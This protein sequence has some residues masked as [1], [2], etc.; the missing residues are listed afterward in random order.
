MQEVI[1]RMSNIRKTFPGV[2]A[3]DEVDLNVRSGTVH[4]LM[5]EN[6]AGKST[7]MKCLI[8]MYQPDSGSVELA[9]EEMNFKDTK[10]GLEHGISMIHQEL[11]PVPEMMVAEN[12]W[13]GRE[14]RGPLGLLDPR[15]MIRKT[16]ELFKEWDIDIDPRAQMK[17]LSI[18]KQQMVEIAKAIS[19]DAKI[20]I[21]D[22]PTS[23]IPEREVEHLHRMIKRLTD[24]GVA[25]IYITHKMDEVFKISD[26]ITIFRD[27]KHV[28]SYAAKDL[29]RDKLIKLMVGRE[30][31]DLFPKLEA[32]IGDVVLSVR[33]LTRGSVV[34]DVSFDLRRGE[35]LGIAGLMGAGRT[36]VL[37]TIFGIEKADSGEIILD[38]KSLRI[39]QPADAIQANLALLTEDRKLN[40]IM[41]VL[42][43]GD[44][45]TVA[46]LPRYSPGG[47]LKVS[48]MRKDS[49]EQREKLRIKTPS[50]N[51]LIKNL[52]GGN[53]QKALISRWLLTVPDVLLIDEPTR[54]IDVGAKSE[55]H[56]LMSLL[57]RQG[58][59]I[60]MVSSE[61]PEVLG[62]SD[63]I[64][65]MHEGRISGE[66]S[67]EEANQE[68]VMHLATGGDGVVASEGNPNV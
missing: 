51:Q 67:R 17:T 68:S 37:E 48:E 47:F 11:S 63:R 23:A 62:M 59:A 66:L 61:L 41:G 64:L 55:I 50:L 19:Y 28:G 13:L 30:L 35:I 33:N 9:G 58:K 25:I 4:S 52:S 24:F 29:D 43:V 15:I 8:G 56:R 44:N 45:I 2:V 32:E 60:I 20:I 6:G 27:G 39:R 49:Q 10:D 31:T 53:Q 57:A 22:E 18:A 54:G 42:S 34:K 65:V 40:G 26:D 12:I 46:A 5:G 16:R 1:L 14:P 38:G 3:L 36:E 21:M 7:L